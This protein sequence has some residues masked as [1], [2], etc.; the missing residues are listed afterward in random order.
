[1]LL[2]SYTLTSTSLPVHLASLVDDFGSVFIF[3][4]GGGEGRRC[5]RRLPEG[6]IH[7]AFF[8]PP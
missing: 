8:L 7:K 3:L 1:M 6:W 5:P 2:E 4:F